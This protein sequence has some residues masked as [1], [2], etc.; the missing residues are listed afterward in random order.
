MRD[1]LAFLRSLR[2][3]GDI[4]RVNLGNHPVYFLTSPAL[5]HEILVTQAGN[6]A[7]GRIYDRTRALFGNGLATSDGT[8]HRQQR[9]LVQP[10]FH[11][12]RIEGY[13]E[14]MSR[15]AQALAQSWRPDQLVAVDEAMYELT[16]KTTVGALFTSDLGRTA[17]DEI[18]RLMPIIM[19]GIP[20]RMITPKLMDRWPIPTNRRFDAAARRLRRLVHDVIAAHPADGPTDTDLL[21]VLLSAGATHALSDD[22]IC[23]EVISILL[24]GTETPAS[25]LAWA[26]HELATH[27]DIER[28]LHTEIDTVVGTRPV[29]HSDLAKLDFTRQVLTE[30]LRL[31]A[32]LLFTRRATT[33]TELGGTRIPAGTE[34]AYS[35][36][37]LHRD[38]DLYPQPTRFD[39]DRLH[40]DQAAK[41]SRAAFQPFSAGRHKCI[42]DNFAWAQMLATV[43]TIAARWRLRPADERAVRE[44]PAVVPRPKSLPMIVTPRSG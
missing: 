34:I 8:F 9:R 17:A 42:G 5:V 27:P 2:A 28:R 23:D 10:V 7:R 4:V 26:L 15:D 22:Q 13:I 37:A 6:F 18:H 1:P 24:A 39:P 3:H 21:S 29:E 40:P 14:V 12:P 36:Y 38:P 35:P 43:A 41:A 20:L 33:D 25:T 11:R 30:V 32:V 19:K 16:L 44:I 31:H